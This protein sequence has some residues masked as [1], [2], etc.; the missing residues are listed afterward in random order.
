M[1]ISKRGFLLFLL[2]TPAFKAF[3]CTAPYQA[4]ERYTE[5]KSILPYIGFSTEEFLDQ[6][7]GKNNWRYDENLFI[8]LPENLE[9]SWVI[10]FEAGI[11]RD[12]PSE[13][14]TE[15]TVYAEEY[16][17]IIFRGKGSKE[18]RVFEIAKF[19]FYESAYP[20]ITTRLN[21]SDSNEVR[22]FCTFTTSRKNWVRVVRQPSIMYT[23]NR[24]GIT[25][26]SKD[27]MS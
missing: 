13:S 8:K 6:T 7:Y 4:I 10:P 11:L 12:D 20:S 24:C 27:E 25:I 21:L 17:P 9:N 22:I 16:I 14:Y 3:S 19:K 2:S 15:L 1:K 23:G 18:K 26:Y 5:K